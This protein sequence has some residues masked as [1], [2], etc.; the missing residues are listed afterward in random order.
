LESFGF[1]VAS[2]VTK[3]VDYLVDEEGKQSSKHTKAKNYGISIVTIKE[4]LI[5]ENINGK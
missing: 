1:K 2:S 3:K 5:E 4:L